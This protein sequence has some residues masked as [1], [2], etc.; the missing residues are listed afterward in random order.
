MATF[1]SMQGMVTGTSPN[2]A[3]TMNHGVGQSLA[4]E[5]FDQDINFDESLLYVLPNC[6][7]QL[8]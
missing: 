8:S 6:L 5:V 2:D 1:N 7:F 3:M 4:M